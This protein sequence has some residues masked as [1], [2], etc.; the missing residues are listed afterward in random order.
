MQT[1]HLFDYMYLLS[2]WM[3]RLDY[4]WHDSDLTISFF[5]PTKLSY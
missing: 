1:C 4:V 5:G 2:E 3:A